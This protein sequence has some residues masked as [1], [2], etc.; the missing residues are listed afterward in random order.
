VSGHRSTMRVMTWNIHGGIG[1]DRRFDLAR[2]VGLIDR[3]DPDVVALQE[4][5]SRGP[6]R[7]GEEDC[8]TFLQRSLGEHGV[9]AKSIIAE[10]GEYGQM[11][12]SRWPLAGTETRDISVPEREPRCA[13]ATD[14][15]S[16]L[17]TFRVVATHLGLSFHERRSQTRILLDLAAT[18][19]GTTVVLGDFNDWMWPGSVRSI[20]SRELPGR[21]RNR[22]FPA[23]FPLLRL[24][25]IYCRPRDALVRSWIDYGARGISD[26]IPVIADIVPVQPEA[27][28]IV[29]EP[30]LAGSEAD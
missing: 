19:H 7:Q 13:I 26:H 2:I 29:R 25:R 24:D 14:V 11:L 28:E 23:L 15:L 18:A 27:R 3:A 5:D 8:F 21:T 9:G 16:P 6:Q 12:I 20:L 22:T 1:R 30:L 4:V 10:D 17:G